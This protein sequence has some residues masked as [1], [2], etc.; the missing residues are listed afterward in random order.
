[1]QISFFFLPLVGNIAYVDRIFAD[2]TIRP[3]VNDR[4]YVGINLFAK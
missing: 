1:M 3:G 4:M 2:K